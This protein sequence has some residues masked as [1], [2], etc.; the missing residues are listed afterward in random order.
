LSV[1]SLKIGKNNCKPG[2]THRKTPFI[3]EIS[4]LDRVNLAEDRHQHSRGGLSKEGC[5][6]N[7]EKLQKGG[8]PHMQTQA[9]TCL[10]IKDVSACGC[11]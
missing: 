10:L 11:G 8:F 4:T 1:V 6:N 9:C 5:E 7:P 2:E 3:H